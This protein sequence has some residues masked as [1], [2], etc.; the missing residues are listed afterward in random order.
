VGLAKRELEER[1]TRLDRWRFATHLRFCPNCR[2]YSMDPAKRFCRNC[3]LY[4][5]DA[6]EALMKDDNR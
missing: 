2:E 3:K 4:E 6:W 5:S 1:E